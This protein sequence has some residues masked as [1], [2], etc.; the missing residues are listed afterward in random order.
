MALISVP[1][2]QALGGRKVPRRLLSASSLPG[3]AI[4]SSA[5]G[6][7]TCELSYLLAGE[8]VRFVFASTADAMSA[9]GFASTPVSGMTEVRV[10]ACSHNQ[11]D[12]RTSQDWCLAVF[13]RAHLAKV[14]QWWAADEREG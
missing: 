8:R 13:E 3:V 7:G 5:S 4:D 14:L 6:V 1:E 2:T 10:D 9:A 11:I 12:F